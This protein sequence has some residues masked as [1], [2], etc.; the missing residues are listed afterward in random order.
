MVNNI[1]NF[2]VINF[3]ENTQHQKENAKQVED[4]TPVHEEKPATSTG[5]FP[6]LTQKCFEEKREQAVEAEIRAA[7][8]GT[9]ESLW[10]T[11]W[12]N[13]N[14]GLV[15]VKHIEAST[16]FRDIEKW[17]GKLPYTERNFRGARNKR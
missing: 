13:E 3:Y 7:C 16:L 9:A 12:D 11:L 4:I 17:Y 14:L 15:E 6:Y 1:N 8:K 2:G 5:H 10:R